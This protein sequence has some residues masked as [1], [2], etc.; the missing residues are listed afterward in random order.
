MTTFNLKVENRDIAGRKVKKLRAEGIMPANIFGKDIQSRSI[1]VD[2]VA[3]S[4][5]FAEAGETGIIEL[6]LDK[7]KVPV[8]VANV[9]THPVTDEPLH[10]DF[11]Q[12][13]MKE[14]IEAQVPVELT[15]EAPAE[16]NGLGIA[17]QQT[18][19]VTVEALPTDLPENYQVDISGLTEVGT[20]I[21][22]ADLPKSDKVTILDETEK[23]IVMIE[24]VPE[25]EEVAPAPVEGAEGEAQAEGETPIEGGEEQGGEEEKASE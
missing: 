21:T 16:K 22:V 13:N 9:Q 12:V 2:R 11:R 24:E 4:K 7:E 14:K 10:V 1:K 20:S 5:I 17:V 25:E 19:E 23:I 6:Q 8:L 18:D 15:G 3:F